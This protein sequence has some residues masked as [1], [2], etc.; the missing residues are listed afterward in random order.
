MFYSFN[1]LSS[2][3]GISHFIS[4]RQGGISPPP[5]DSLNLGFHTTDSASTVQENRAILA[6]KLGVE[7][8]KFVYCNQVHGDIVKIIT[9]ENHYP[10]PLVNEC[11]AMV[12]AVR[13]LCLIIQV[14]DCVPILFYDP[15]NG[16]VAAA[17]AGWR[18]TV[19][20]IAGKT[21]EVMTESFGCR[22]ENIQAGIGPSIGPCCYEVGEE[23]VL[24]ARTAMLQDALLPG[25]KQV[26]DLWR[27]NRIQLLNA[28]LQDHNIEISGIC[29]RCHS[30]Q[31]F[32]SRAGQGL[33]GRF[34]AG[35]MLY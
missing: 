9:G 4:S 28:G 26:F 10:D 7:P 8:G 16:V 32:S 18:G 25:E 17:H 20:N 33:T 2:F 3:Q 11:D 29:T 30:G 15:E 5:F 24:E 6:K 27:A 21:V 13:G 31:F 19:K 12:T 1:K 23:V 35:I 14:A 22:K 34:G